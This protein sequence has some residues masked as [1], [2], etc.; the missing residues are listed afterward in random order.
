M[1]KL[2][3]SITLIILFAYN[4][5]YL[6]C[7][8]FLALPGA[9]EIPDAFGRNEEMSLLFENFS[10]IT[11]ARSI[12]KGEDLPITASLGNIAS[13]M[14]ICLL[15]LHYKID[16]KI[17]D[18]Q[19]I[20]ESLYDNEKGLALLQEFIK[21][22]HVSSN[23]YFFQ[24]FVGS[25]GSGRHPFEQFKEYKYHEIEDAVRKKL[26]PA[27]LFSHVLGKIFIS[28]R[29]NGDLKNDLVFP[30]HQEISSDEILFFIAQQHAKS[31]SGV[32]ILYP[33]RKQAHTMPL[34]TFI[35]SAFE[36]K[37]IKPERKDLWGNL[38]WFQNIQ[39]QASQINSNISKPDDLRKSN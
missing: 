38:L 25:V 15:K 9:S 6:H 13:K 18:S 19:I 10:G 29:L 7:S 27:L 37:S 21:I 17:P 4:I 1:N 2:T 16:K 20:D 36:M 30:T 33:D 5:T 28:P 3:I 32:E 24:G 8:K 31:T 26:I 39:H 12:L 35:V 14:I 34:E 22:F 23:L 11:V